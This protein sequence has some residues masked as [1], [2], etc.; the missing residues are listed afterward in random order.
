MAFAG[1]LPPAPAAEEKELQT[2]NFVLIGNAAE[3]N[4]EEW[5][6]L[7]EERR[8]AIADQLG[9]YYL[10]R[11]EQKCRVYLAR[12]AGELSQQSRAPWWAKGWSRVDLNKN[13]RSA[14]VQGRTIWVRVDLASA[15]LEPLFSHEIAHLLFREFLEFP[16]AFPIWLDEGVAV[17]AENRNRPIYERTIRQAIQRE[18]IFPLNLFFSFEDY[19]ADKKLFYSQASSII[20]YL[21]SEHGVEAFQRFSRLIRDGMPTPEAMFQVYQVNRADLPDFERRWKEWVI[22]QES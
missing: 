17:W 7:V 6:N 1:G 8:R 5:G 15:E 14:E 2:D 3:E 10:G 13:R 19:P 4:L 18:K 21:I 22:E 11:W 9:F 20:S 16:D 12:S